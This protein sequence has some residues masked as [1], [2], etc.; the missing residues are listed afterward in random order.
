[1]A[2]FQ[3]MTI[4]L[5]III[6]VCLIRYLLCVFLALILISNTDFKTASFPDIS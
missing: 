2:K 6:E 4:F 3:V 1:M 5:N